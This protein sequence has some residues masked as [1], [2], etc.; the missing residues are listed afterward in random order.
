MGLWLS[1]GLFAKKSG[2]LLN[3]K[4]R[5]L[6]DDTKWENKLCYS[7]GNELITV[8]VEKLKLP[9]RCSWRRLSLAFGK[10]I[11]KRPGDRREVVC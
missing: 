7:T 4:F 5:V 1:F 6:P 2:F 3:F 10:N 9:W 8:K 11:G